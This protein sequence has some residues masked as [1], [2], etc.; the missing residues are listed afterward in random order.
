MP[1][2]RRAHYS[3]SDIK[4]AFVDIRRLNRTMTAAVGAENLG[5]NDQDVVSIIGGL[6]SRDF[7]KSMPSI[8][9][10]DVMQDVYK[11]TINGRELYIKF[12]LMQLDG[13]C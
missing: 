2:A 6:N 12:T 10:P 7:E 13:C 1:R 11:P 4:A 3:L 8:V 5:V 9:S